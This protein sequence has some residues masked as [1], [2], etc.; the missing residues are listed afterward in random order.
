M[1][2]TEFVFR[3]PSE[4]SRDLFARDEATLSPSYTR[5]YGLSISHGKGSELWDLDGN[6]YVDFASGIAVMSTG[7]SHPRVVK[8]IQE[9]AEKY[10]H[11]GATDFYCPQPVAL[12]ERLQQ[13]VPI[14]NTEAQ[15]KV[16]YFGNSGTES[17]EA[18]LKLARYKEGR[19][20]VIGFYGSFHGRTMGA[21]SVTAS[22]SV[23]R[24]GYPHIPDGVTHVPY[25]GRNSCE[26]DCGGSSCCSQCWCDAVGFIEKFVLKKVAPHEIAAVIV[27]P[28]QGEGGYIVPRDD[29][30][31]KLRAF[32]DKYGIL[33]IA[34]EIQSGVGRTGKFCAMEHWG[35]AADIVCLAKGLGS[36]VPIGA[37][38]ASRRVMGKWIPGAHASTFGGNP[39]ACAAAIAT[40]DVVEEEGLMENAT[41]L[42]NYTMARLRKFMASQPVITR[43]DGKGFMLGMDFSNPNGTPFSEF[44]EAVVNECYLSGLVTLGCGSAGLRFAPALTLSKPLLDEGLDILERAIATVAEEMYPA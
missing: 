29:F 30:F 23:Q 21:L 4:A 40:L 41:T 18:A 5:S 8:A 42:G 13:L 38:I 34:D 7:F 24:A 1:V 17:I 14:H 44:R 3:E 35:V 10:T 36:G 33:L 28:I 16:V 25:P 39:L 19:S 26:D 31:P 22:K 12:A 9:Q 20:H 43:V 27:E 6:R 11:I 15:D 37:V 2:T 32:C